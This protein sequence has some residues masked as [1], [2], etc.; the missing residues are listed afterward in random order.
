MAKIIIFFC[1]L[2]LF[3]NFLE[4]N[5]IDGVSDI[6]NVENKIEPFRGL[7]IKRGP[8][9]WTDMI[10]LCCGACNKPGCRYAM[11]SLCC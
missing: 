11:C 2:A 1:V 8:V 4:S 7:R 6:E 5:Q 10:K 9:C 3:I